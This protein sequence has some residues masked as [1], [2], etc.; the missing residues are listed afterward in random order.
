MAQREK[1]LFKKK[2]K[3]RKESAAIPH[4]WWGPTGPLPPGV[5]AK[6]QTPGLRLS[7]PLTS[8]AG[9]TQRGVGHPPLGSTSFLRLGSLEH[10]VLGAAPS[11]T[12]WTPSRHLAPTPQLLA[13]VG[14]LPWTPN[15]LRTT[16]AGLV[17]IWL[18]LQAPSCPCGRTVYL[19][20]LLHVASSYT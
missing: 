19:A 10:G 7:V 17:S 6:S 4:C 18:P 11:P 16:V 2:K 3:R 12:L 1:R 20:P 14:I 13:D 15:Q 8:W 5:T 9:G